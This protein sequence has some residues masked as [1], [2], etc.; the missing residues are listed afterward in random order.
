MVKQERAIRTRR[1]LVVAAAAEFDRDG[2]DGTSLS[3]ISRAAG[4]SMGALTFHFQAKSELA[5]A[6]EEA[7]R[8]VTRAALDK[9]TATGDP[10]L[11]QVAALMTELILLVERNPE[12]RAAVRL[13]RERPGTDGWTALWLPVAHLLLRHAHG[14][15]QLRAEARPDDVTTLV[16]HLVAGAAAHL[17]HRDTA[18]TD[19]VAPL[20][21]HNW[22]L[23]LTG[24]ATAEPGVAVRNHPPGLS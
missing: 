11:H 16:R 20:L 17:R 14:N 7:G 8:T 10:P 1:A 18:A 24:I 6:V 12:V 5:E 23:V 21:A 15:G 19:D 13:E 22:Q 9:V 2:Y 3:R 4:I